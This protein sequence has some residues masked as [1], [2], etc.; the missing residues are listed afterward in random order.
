M[1]DKLKACG[2]YHIEQWQDGKL[3]KKERIKN[4]VVQNF[5]TAVYNSLADVAPMD[6]PITHLA[7]GDSITA[8]MRTDTALGNELFRKAISTVTGGTTNF[9]AKT[10]LTPDESNFTIRE[11]G[12]FSD[13]TLISRVNVNIAKNENVQLLITYTLEII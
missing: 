6:F 2:V 7:T 1:K 4:V 12:L 10:S 11:I 8:A 13:T 9:T 3:I 5:F